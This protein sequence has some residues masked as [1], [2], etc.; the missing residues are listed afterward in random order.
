M[1]TFGHAS[2]LGS[3][4]QFNRQRQKIAAEFPAVERERQDGSRP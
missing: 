4:G 1:V 3:E 2:L